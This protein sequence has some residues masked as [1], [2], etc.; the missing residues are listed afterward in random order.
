MLARNVN[1][2]H[3]FVSVTNSQPHTHTWATAWPQTFSKKY[4][5][6]P[7]NEAL[8]LN[9]PTQWLSVEWAYIRPQAWPSG[10]KRESI[11]QWSQNIQIPQDVRTKC[12]VFALP[13]DPGLNDNLNGK[14][15]PSPGPSTQ[16]SRQTSL[17]T[18]QIL[19]HFPTK[20]FTL[21]S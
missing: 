11:T 3:A 17:F 6:N 9:K 5:N 21:C 20:Y 2:I 7:E 14:L 12:Q 18:P 1:L 15:V 8:I 13:P 19:A 4:V 10:K 16:P